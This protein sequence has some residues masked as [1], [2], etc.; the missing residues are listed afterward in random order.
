MELY[1][2]V[3]TED[4][5]RRLGDTVQSW[6]S[7]HAFNIAV[8][9]LGAY[10]LR[11]FGTGLIS[12]VISR[13]VRRDLFPTEI[14]R[15][16]RVKTLNSL[17][18]ATMRIGVWFIAGIMIISELGINT[19]PL[20][21]GASILGVALGFGAQS[22]VK[23]FVSGIFIITENQY[24]VG[25]T[26][27]LGAIHGKVEAVTIRTTVLRDLD[28]YVHHVPN[29]TITV[30][31]NKTIGRGRLNEDI[32]VPLKTDLERLEHVIKHVGDELAAIP[33]LKHK[34]IEPPVL[35]SI[36]GFHDKGLTVKITGTTAS[37]AYWQV[38]SEFYRLLKK[39]LDKHSIDAVLTTHSTDT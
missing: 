13:T 12:G 1:P 23:D 4:N 33:E 37:N 32:V 24:R 22:L 7:E 16:K 9:L 39:A 10:I 36:K 34:L 30:T 19:G 31:T 6:A 28:G 15:K 11:K 27:Q 5:I 14:D 25:D 38:R 2:L 26:V 3:G 17:A 29:G 18:G 20:L 21:A 8:I 35:T